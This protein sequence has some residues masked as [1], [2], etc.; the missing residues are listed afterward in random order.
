MR[1][2]A[3]AGTNKLTLPLAGHPLVQYPVLAALASR[4]TPVLTVTGSDAMAVEWV[5][6][7][8]AVGEGMEILFNPRFEEGLSTSLAAGIAE[9]PEDVAG[10]VVLLGDMPFVSAAIIDQL[11]AAF[12]R[13]P[14]APAI[15]P[16]CGGAWANPVLLARSL[17]PAIARLTG[18]TGAR[19]LL[20][21]RSGVVTLAIDDPALILDADDPDSLEQM[22][23]IAGERL[24]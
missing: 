8:I 16:T 21:G 3:F 22:R 23:L 17:F 10:A 12:E 4:A 1:R 19:K 7:D 6:S 5:L 20:A 2:G 9:L 13:A 11:I 24:S 18:D 15:V 14:E